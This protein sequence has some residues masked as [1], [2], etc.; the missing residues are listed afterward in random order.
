MRSAFPQ[1]EVICDV[2]TL[3]FFKAFSQ[4]IHKQIVELGAAFELPAHPIP[5]VFASEGYTQVAQ[6]STTARAAEL[7]Q[8]PWF[9]RLML[10]FSKQF[11]DGYSIRVFEPA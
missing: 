2:M 7:G 8:M 5:G 10:V 3:E 4:P 11:V 6:I 9:M 1:G